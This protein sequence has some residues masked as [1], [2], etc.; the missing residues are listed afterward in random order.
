MTSTKQSHSALFT[1]AAAKRAVKAL[2]VNPDKNIL[3]LLLKALGLLLRDPV[4]N[5]DD[6]CVCVCVRFPQL[7]AEMQDIIVLFLDCMSNI[8]EVL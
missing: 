8:A 5:A 7:L 3:I 2:P 6:V 4:G 1:K